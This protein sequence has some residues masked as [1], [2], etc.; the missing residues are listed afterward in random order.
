MHA[1]Y[2]TSNLLEALAVA[3]LI[4][5][6]VMSLNSCALKINPD[7]SKEVTVDAPTAIKFAE[8]YATK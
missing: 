1:R 7:G 2:R 8:I 6:F 4:L 3:L 5:A